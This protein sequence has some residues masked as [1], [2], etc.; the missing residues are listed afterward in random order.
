MISAALLRE[1]PVPASPRGTVLVIGG[2]RAVPGAVLLTG[3]AALRAGASTLQLAASERHAVALGVAVPEASVFG[4]PETASGAIS[5]D[6]SGA[7]ADVLPEAD[8]VV[9]GPGLND[10]DE[11]GALLAEL[12]VGENAQ[13]VLDAFALG[14]LSREP[15]LGK[16]VMGRLVLTP[17]VTEAAFLLDRQEEKITDYPAAASKIAERY[18]A[19]VTLMGGIA[20]PDG[21]A[22]LE[23]SGHVGLAKSGSGDV[24][25]GL[26]G[27]FLSRSAT[28]AQA[29]CWATHVH[30][31]AGQRLIPRA[32]VSGLLARELVEQVPQVIAELSR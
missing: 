31:M 24:L 10:V 29:T 7:L 2:S 15:D 5:R 12:R 6:A 30:A 11:T 20:D 25:A 27:G 23:Q 14:A 28:P 8:V 19:V 17:N 21:H 9:V 18:G 16:P 3:T 26:V 13:V 1:W 22:W 4:L 32:G